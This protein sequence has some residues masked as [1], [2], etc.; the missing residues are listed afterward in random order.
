[1]TRDQKK[2]E[3]DAIISN[4]SEHNPKQFRIFMC[5]DKGEP[6]CAWLQ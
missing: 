5:E 4:N 6:V 3:G 1:M 2:A